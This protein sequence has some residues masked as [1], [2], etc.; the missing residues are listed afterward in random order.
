LLQPRYSGSSSLHASQGHLPLVQNEFQFPA[1]AQT[2]RLARY[3]AK[4]VKLHLI[5]F[6][7][8]GKPLAQ[9]NQDGPFNVTLMAKTFQFEA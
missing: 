2:S 1:I 8:V 6:P 9:V 7:E 4:V 3:D 5:I